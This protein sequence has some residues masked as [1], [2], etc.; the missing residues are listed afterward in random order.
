MPRAKRPSSS[1]YARGRQPPGPGQAA[2]QP[3]GQ[4][5]PPPVQ[6]VQPP[7]APGV[8]PPPVQVAPPP[9][10]PGQGV[11]PPHVQAVPQPPGL[12]VLPPPGPV[13]PPPHVPVLDG[14]GDDNGINGDNLIPILSITDSLGGHV[15]AA[16]RLRI[17]NGDFI[18]LGLLLNNSPGLAESGNRVSL[19]AGQLVVQARAST[20]KTNNIKQWSDA[21]L[22]YISLYVA[23]HPD[24]TQGLLKYMSIIRLGADRYGGLGWHFYDIQFRLKK[25]RDP[26]MSWGTVDQELWL[27]YMFYTPIPSEPK[28]N[29]V[30]KCY[31][32]NNSMCNKGFC[33]FK[34]IC[35][36]CSE[37]HPAWRCNT[38]GVG[39]NNLGSVSNF[40]FGNY[41][42]QGARF[43]SRP[44]R[45]SYRASS[46]AQ[47]LPRGFPRYS[48]PR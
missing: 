44:I 36:H 14:I 26:S 35:M 12:A 15:N 24:E 29:V 8:Q 7:A 3:T 2:P 47:S 21:F 20:Q 33:S 13:A 18:E 42:Q 17:A 37:G 46:P 38:R 16:L 48:G 40:R 32:Y 1:P 25:A 6:A 4:A 39:Q 34:H 10:P 41:T 43:S 11:P 30:R 31:D 22:V 5:M 23:S 9:P 28:R 45:P 19:V 27:L